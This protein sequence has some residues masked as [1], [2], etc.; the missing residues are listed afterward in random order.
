MPGIPVRDRQ[1]L[2]TR[3]VWP[4]GGRGSR[5]SRAV[6]GKVQ[7]EAPG[8]WPPGTVPAEEGWG[9]ESKE[10]VPDHPY[11]TPTGGEVWPGS[12]LVEQEVTGGQASLNPGLAGTIWASHLVQGG[13]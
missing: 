13:N 6:W 9:L 2:P 7:V 1:P 5:D 8:A 4:V 10:G 12:I 3:L 11:C